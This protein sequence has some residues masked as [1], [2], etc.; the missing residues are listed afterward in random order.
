MQALTAEVAVKEAAE[1]QVPALAAAAAA[2]TALVCA[3]E[4]EVAAIEAEMAANNATGDSKA[5]AAAR[6][7]TVVNGE[8]VGR[9]VVPPQPLTQAQQQRVETFLL[10]KGAARP[11]LALLLAPLLSEAT[12]AEYLK[13]WQA[14]AAH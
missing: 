2:M 14:A 12:Q 4:A 10:E 8:E 3:M 6:L 1:A 11:Q 13:R 9:I 5:A 7:V